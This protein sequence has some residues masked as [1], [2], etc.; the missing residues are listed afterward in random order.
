MLGGMKIYSDFPVRRTAQIVADILALVVISFGIWLG[1]AV[2]A[3]IAV[4]AE[5]GRQ[6]E[7]AGLGFQGAMT[8]AGDVL[9]QLPFIGDAARVPFDAAS[10]TGGALASA[11]NT[12]ESFILA[13]AAIVGAIVAVVI[14][15]VVLLVWLRRRIAFIRRATEA[16]K[17]ARMGDGQE[18]LALRS[19]VGASRQD[20]AAT[21]THPV[22]AWRSG[23]AGVVMRL[24][25]LELR[26][27]G[28]RLAR[29]A[30]R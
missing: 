8:D 9:G 19:L 10:G 7:N 26:A 5:V 20:L 17:L 22:Q 11:G 21:S 1:L 29:V 18:L 4:L 15:A 2:T 30:A 24:A 23:E 13:T 25:E 3:A 12:T 16:S 6:V 28:V 27:A 14:V